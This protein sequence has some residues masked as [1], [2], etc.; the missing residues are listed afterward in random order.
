MCCT[1][2]YPIRYKMSKKFLRS[3]RYIFTNLFLLVPLRGGGCEE[4]GNVSPLAMMVL[5]FLRVLVKH[6]NSLLFLFLLCCKVD[7]TL[8]YDD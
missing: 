6:Q 8:S 3:R 7:A 1:A 2:L 5:D 4:A